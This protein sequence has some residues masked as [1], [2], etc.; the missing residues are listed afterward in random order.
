MSMHPVE[1]GEGVQGGPSGRL[2]NLLRRSP[3]PL[4]PGSPDRSSGVSGNTKGRNLALG[5]I[6]LSNSHLDKTAIVT[7]DAAIPL[8]DPSGTTKSESVR[9]KEL[10]TSR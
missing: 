4:S 10:V 5:E 9:L 6:S 8:R 3:I 7:L 2:A 1:L